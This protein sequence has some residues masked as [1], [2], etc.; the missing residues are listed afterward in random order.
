MESITRPQSGCLPAQAVLFSMELATARAA[1]SASASDAAPLTLTVTNLSAPSPSC[2]II[3]A[4]SW[5]TFSKAWK[6]VFQSLEF[7]LSGW[8]PAAP[9][10]RAST[11]SLVLWSPSIEMRLKLRSTA[12]FKEAC[13]AC[14][15]TVASVAM[16]D[17]MVAML[18]SI[19]PAPLAK[20]TIFTVRPSSCTSATETLGRVSVVI[21]AS[22]VSCTW[23]IRAFS[24]SVPMPETILSN[25]SCGPIFPVEQT[26]ISCGS[27]PSNLAV[28]A[29]MSFAAT[30]PLEPVQALAI[31]L[32]MT[33]A[34]AIPC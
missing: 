8:M 17:S 3:I 34:R 22:A 16:N 32:F 23:P 6:K 21:I 9:L 27:Q 13:S 14:G 29:A 11:V 12:L 15:S 28:S 26:K 25:G 4:S 24:T 7:S 1:N 33:M 30:M 31:P 2:T 19:I 5:Q 20:P 10:A 18:G